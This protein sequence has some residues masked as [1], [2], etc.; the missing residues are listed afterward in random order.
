MKCFG[1]GEWSRDHSVYVLLQLL[2]CGLKTWHLLTTRSW[3]K[4]GLFKISTSDHIV[5]MFASWQK[6]SLHAATLSRRPSTPGGRR[7][8]QPLNRHQLTIH[9][10][11]DQLQV[12][13]WRHRLASAAGLSKTDYKVRCDNNNNQS[14]NLSQFTKLCKGDR[15]LRWLVL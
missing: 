9:I 1:V 7:M 14:K 15:Y 11:R 4:T 5:F 6:W 10:A 3:K 12:L 13:W 2:Q 8:G